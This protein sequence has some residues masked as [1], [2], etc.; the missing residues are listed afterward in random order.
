MT[1]LRALKKDNLSPKYEI[2][3][4]PKLVKMINVKKIKEWSN[5]NI[6]LTFSEESIPSNFLANIPDSPIVRYS[7]RATK[8]TKKKKKTNLF[9]FFY[10]MFLK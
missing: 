4:L 10:L 1:N 5:P 9:L 2:R 6:V 3:A 8:V 7:P